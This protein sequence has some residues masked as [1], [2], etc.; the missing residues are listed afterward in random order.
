MDSHFCVAQ[1][2]YLILIAHEVLLN[3]T[4]SEDAKVYNKLHALH[5][6]DRMYKMQ[7]FQQGGA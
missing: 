5:L 1:F 6:L 3:L 2:G 7:V 4:A